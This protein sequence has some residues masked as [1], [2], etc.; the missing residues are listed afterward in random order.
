M[1]KV[2]SHTSD[3]QPKPSE[4]PVLTVNDAPAPTMLT[5]NGG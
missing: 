5:V 1:L 4:N 2:S 3:P